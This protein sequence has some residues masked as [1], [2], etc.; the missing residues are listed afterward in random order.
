MGYPEIVEDAKCVMYLNFYEKYAVRSLS[1][2]VRH[3][4]TT[5][6]RLALSSTTGTLFNFFDYSHNKAR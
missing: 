5:P 3:Y 6:S 4:R 1:C 2:E